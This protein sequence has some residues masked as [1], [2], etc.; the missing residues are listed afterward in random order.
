[1]T[2][3]MMSMVQCT[4]PLNRGKW[5]N[6]NK[7]NNNIKKSKQTKNKNQKKTHIVSKS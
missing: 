5:N 4:F 1:M 6:M 3:M 7:N 2:N